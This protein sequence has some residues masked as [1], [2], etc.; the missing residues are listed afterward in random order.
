MTGD[1]KISSEKAREILTRAAEID[2]H[3]ADAVSIETLRE[4]AREAGI[5][6][7]SIAAALAE[8]AETEGRG[9]AVQTRR[10]TLVRAFAVIGAGGVLLIVM[11][12]LTRLFP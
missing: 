5:A 10:R 7:S 6:E 3:A 9:L 12:L 4:A 1:S 8:H 2:R 11:A